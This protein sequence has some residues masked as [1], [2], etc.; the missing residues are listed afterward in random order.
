MNTKTTPLLGRLSAALTI[1][2]FL[3][4]TVTMARAS[5]SLTLT[6][7]PDSDPHLAGYCV[8]YGTASGE[9]L[10]EIQAGNVTSTT[11][12]NLTNGG[13]YYFVVSAL[14]SSGTQSAPSGEIIVSTPAVVF[15]GL[16]NGSSYNA[17]AAITLSVVASELGE[18]IVDVDYF[19]GTILIGSSTGGPFNVVWTGAAAGNHTVT[20][21]AYDANGSSSSTNITI[22]VVPFAVTGMGFQAD[23][24][25][26]VTI[27][28]AIGKTDSLYCSTDLVSWTL[29]AA[30]ANTAGTLTMVDPGADQTSPDSQRFYKVES[31]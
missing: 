12:N 2:L 3:C 10:Q 9:Y 1:F 23:G 29:I 31:N 28:G 20:A 7:N 18:S 11:I 21:V 27:T 22:S 25:F 15:N 14:D 17:A 6:W 5:A 13:T 30:T 16:A 4:A 19:E 26:Q 24:D 8:Y